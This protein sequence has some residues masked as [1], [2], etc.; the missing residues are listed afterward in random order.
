M[1]G[2]KAPKPFYQFSRF[3][4][5]QFSIKTMCLYI[6]KIIFLTTCCHHYLESPFSA[7]NVLFVVSFHSDNQVFLFFLFLFFMLHVP[8]SSKWQEMR[9]Q[10]G[11]FQSERPRNSAV[12]VQRSQVFLCMKLL[13][14]CHSNLLHS[15][16]SLVHL[17][18][19]GK[20]GRISSVGR[21]V[22]CRGGCSGFHSPA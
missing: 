14:G 19:T 17:G 21:A 18:S 13:C 22:D 20:G 10:Q 2:K 6:S 11:E 9:Q 4:F 12:F 5:Q 8:H 3:P 16:A 1:P 15:Y 7:T